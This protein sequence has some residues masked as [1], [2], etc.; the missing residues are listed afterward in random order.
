MAAAI[1]PNGQ[2]DWTSLIMVVIVGIVITG[3][4]LTTTLPLGIYYRVGAYILCIVI[5]G[6]TIFVNVNA[7]TDITFIPDQF[8]V[9]ATSQ[10]PFIYDPGESPNGVIVFSGNAS[11]FGDQ[12]NCNLKSQNSYWDGTNQCQC[13]PGFYGITCEFQGFGNDYVSLTTTTPYTISTLPSS[14][15]PSLTTWPLTTVDGCTNQCTANTNCIGVTYAGTTCT[16]ITT[17]NFSS[18]APIQTSLD[19]PILDTTLYLNKARL[20]AVNLAGYFNVIYGVLPVRY[21]VGNGISAGSPNPVHVTPSGTRIAYYAVGINYT[22]G[23]IPDYIIVGTNGTL[24]ISPNVIPPR[25]SIV[26]GQS[27]LFAAPTPIL[28]T[29]QQFPFTDPTKSYYVRLDPS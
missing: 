26:P 12:Y 5:A 28:L 2:Y 24:Y 29:K 11:A 3:I 21:F 19:P 8:A 14:S 7:F 17:L 1:A 18:G 4:I 20:L 6:V 13:K 27:T 9:V 23:G 10:D 25:A 22:I 15:V 16:Q